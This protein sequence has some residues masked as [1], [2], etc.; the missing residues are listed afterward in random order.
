MSRVLWF[1]FLGLA[2]TPPLSAQEPK[3]R[4]TFEGHTAQVAS[5]VFN[6]D[7]KTLA[8]GSSDCTIKLWNVATG[9]NVA[10]LNAQPD[11]VTCV[12]FSPDG[13]TLA[14]GSYYCDDPDSLTMAHGTLHNAIKLWDVAS[15]KLTA[16]LK[17][18]TDPITSVAFNHDGGTLA[19]GSWDKTIKFWDVATGKNIATMENTDGVK[20][21]AFSPDGKTL[22][23]VLTGGSKD[24]TIKLWDV[25]T[26]KETAAFDAVTIT[27]ESLVFSPDGKTLASACGREIRLWDLATGKNT[28]TL[29]G[30][31]RGIYSLAFSPDGKTLASG[32]GS[33]DEDNTIKL[34]DLETGKNT[35]TLTGHIYTVTSVAFSPDGRTLASGSNDKT[36]KLWDI[37]R[38]EFRTW[39]ESTGKHSVEAKF[40]GLT[41]GKA[42]LIKKDGTVIQVPVE[43]LSAEDQ[44]WIKAEKK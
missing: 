38:P 3:L 7:G 23:S 20:S 14:S 27:P 36:I 42:K 26:R 9:K 19:S 28:S 11:E 39:S 15:S 40:D 12:A 32:A 6:P 8:S 34:W 16:T 4:Q 21:V 18:H 37:P 44:E 2:A 17:G 41:S 1:V 5:V 22:A 33:A 25:A 29:T 13:K 24:R 10:M 30:H 43:K 35:F 31:T